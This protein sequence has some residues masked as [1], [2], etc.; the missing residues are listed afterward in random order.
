MGFSS[1]ALWDAGL[2]TVAATSCMCYGTD[3]LV[4]PAVF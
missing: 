4:L 3:C 1:Q 2:L